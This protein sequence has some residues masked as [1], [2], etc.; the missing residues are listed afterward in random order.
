[1]PSTNELISEIISKTISSGRYVLTEYESKNILREISVPIPEYKL[2]RSV[3]E[4]L[5]AAE[6]LG[7]PVVLK[8]T[9]PDIIH[10]SDYGGVM[11]NLTDKKDVAEAYNKIISNVSA[12]AKHA[13]I[14][15]VMVSKMAPRGIVEL[16]I[17][18]SFDEQFGHTIMVGLGG[19]F[20]ELLKDFSM[21]LIP[22][23]DLDAEEMLKELKAYPILN[24]YRSGCKADIK[25]I[26]ETLLKISSLV[27]KYP[28][29]L[30][31][32]LNPVIVYENGLSVVDA[33]IILRGQK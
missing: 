12:K 5:E 15:G 14:D 33:R 10:K 31:L 21:R 32:D 7:Y 26:K 9:S 2:V 8:I 11:L 16:I 22:I 25:S 17:G 29:I 23:S 27:L 18:V 20:V 1:M 13:R 4:A 3:K 30:E 24:G 19:V 28:E 6:K